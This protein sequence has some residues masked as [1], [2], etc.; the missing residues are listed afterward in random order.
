MTVRF[1]TKLEPS[2]L[3]PH[4]SGDSQPYAPGDVLMHHIE[5]GWTI[6]NVV[7]VET[8]HFGG[9]RQVRVI[10]VSLTAQGQVLAMPAVANPTVE[11][12]LAEHGIRPI[13]SRVEGRLPEFGRAE[14]LA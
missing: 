4:W 7:T 2:E 14:C 3:C 8:V 12:L 6:G 9:T 11:R 10:H 13:A 1:V 5:S